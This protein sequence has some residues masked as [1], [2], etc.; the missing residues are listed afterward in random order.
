MFLKPLYN[1]VYGRSC[2]GSPIADIHEFAGSTDSVLGSSDDGTVCS[3][4]LEDTEGNLKLKQ[5]DAN[6]RL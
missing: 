3:L 1:I 5:G 4:F 6:N 2:N